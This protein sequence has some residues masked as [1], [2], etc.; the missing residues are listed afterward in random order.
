[1]NPI[2][3]GA[4]LLVA[5]GLAG[6][7]GGASAGHAASGSAEAIETRTIAL[8][9]A[10]ITLKSYGRSV[11]GKF[12]LSVFDLAAFDAVPRR[13]HLLAISSAGELLFRRTFTHA[14][15]PLSLALD[16]KP[17]EPGLYMYSY[18]SLKASAWPLGFG[19]FHF[20][21]KSFHDVFPFPVPEETPDARLEMHDA[22]RAPNGNYFYLF[23][24]KSGQP[25]RLDVEIQEWNKNGEVVF[26]WSYLEHF[27]GIDD[28]SPSPEVNAMDIDARGDILIS[29]INDDEILKIEH[30]SGKVSWRLSSR[31]WRFVGDSLNGFHYQHSVKA[32][33]N[34]NV[35]MFDNG[36]RRVSRAVEYEL[37]PASATAKLVWEHRDSSLGGQRYGG[38]VQRLSNGNTLIGW[39]GI[40]GADAKKISTRVL[41]TEVS[42]SGEIVRELISSAPA[43]A[44]RVNLEE[45]PA[46]P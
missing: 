37:D 30:P 29:L 20:L 17:V 25:A 9:A 14:F 15:K 36:V 35:L 33:P 38:S 19:A 6:V 46:S 42:P 27:K 10:A 24:R 26:T 43:G 1:M 22:V 39:G 41:C 40:F 5:L 3:R 16:F 23:Y 34:G 13:S 45:T 4:R 8:D 32:L 21:D 28:A 31:K 12:L 7:V 18:G 11:S 2:R 44:Y